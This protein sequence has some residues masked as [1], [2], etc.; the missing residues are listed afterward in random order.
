MA[1]YTPSFI[2]EITEEDI[3]SLSIKELNR[4]LKQNNTSIYKSVEIKKQRRKIKMK[5]Y[6]KDNRMRK[7]TKVDR[8]TKERDLL[9]DELSC[10]KREMIVLCRMKELLCELTRVDNTE[11]GEYVVVD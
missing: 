8:L 10:I 1:S 4:K 6:R 2:E 11:H 5:K 9:H 3:I 7:A